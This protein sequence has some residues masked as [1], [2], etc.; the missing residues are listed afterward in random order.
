MPADCQADKSK[1][2]DD[3]EVVAK[4]AGNRL[5]FY[6][7]VT[8]EASGYVTVR[9]RSRAVLVSLSGLTRRASKSSRE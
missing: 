4:R 1:Y 3:P 2:E 6:V 8:P 9:A 7:H 5:Y